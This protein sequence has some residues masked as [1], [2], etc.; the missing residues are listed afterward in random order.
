[1]KPASLILA[2]LAGSLLLQPS[3][4]QVDTTLLPDAEGRRDFLLTGYGF[5][6]A[7]D[8]DGRASSF[9]VGFNPILL[10]KLDDNLLFESE[11]EFELE[12][13]ETV[14]ELEYAQILF[15]L[16]D[17]VTVGAGKF[18]S[19]NNSFME[20]FHPAW[21]NKLPDMPFGMS[22]HGGVQLLASTQIGVQGRGGI[23][24]GTSKFVY[25]V[26]ISNGPALN[27]E[28]GHD[29]AG[30][31]VEGSGQ[32]HGAAAVGTLNFANTSDNN[33]NKAF[34]GRIAILPIPQLEVGYG[35][36]TAEVSNETGDLA[37]VRSLNNVVDLTYVG[38]ISPLKGRIDI[39]GQYMWLDI[40]NPD[41]HP[42]EFE[43][44]SNGGYVQ[45][46][47][48]P[49]H[50]GNAFVGNVEIVARYD[51]LDLPS[52]APVNVD[53]ERITFGV[54]YWLSASSVLKFAFESITSEQDN[55]EKTESKLL[56]QFALGF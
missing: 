56:A 7:E 5:T 27:V 24:V 49:Y 31:V 3:L 28:D 21:I 32:G 33:G 43:N 2:F 26:Y 48:Q 50:I 11:L 15:V 35:M 34:G 47:Y 29:D 30:G 44:A 41:K 20:R 10:W 38:D 53:Q 25:A 8:A 16:N 14:V 36:E 17:Y 37:G 6:S 1:M 40:D 51:R 13:G 46:A 18:L 12:D 23:R 9:E 4:A 54:N 55:E 42:L 39:R 19:P 52:G 45:I 22:G